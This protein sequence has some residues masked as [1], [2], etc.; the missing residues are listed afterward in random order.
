MSNDRTH[1]R[2]LDLPP[3]TPTWVMEGG[4]GNHQ[5]CAKSTLDYTNNG[6]KARLKA[7]IFSKKNKKSL[8][9]IVG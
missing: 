6:T 4:G 5:Q 1:S 2:I 8:K 7:L 3:I 9:V